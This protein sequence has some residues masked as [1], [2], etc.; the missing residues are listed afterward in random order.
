MYFLAGRRTRHYQGMA[1]SLR[2]HQQPSESG[3]HGSDGIRLR[4][5]ELDDLIEPAGLEYP[6][7]RTG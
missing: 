6:A 4:I 7:D 3:T 1:R 5:M 2:D